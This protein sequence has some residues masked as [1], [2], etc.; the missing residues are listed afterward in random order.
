MVS[1]VSRHI[2][3][4]ACACIASGGVEALSNS[5]S[6][7]SPVARPLVN[8]VLAQGLVAAAFNYIC[9]LVT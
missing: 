6:S 8:V 9:K 3:G 1:T 4:L 7:M 2:S 5:S